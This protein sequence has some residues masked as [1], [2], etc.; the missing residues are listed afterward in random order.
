MVVSVEQAVSAPYATRQLADL[1]ARVIKVE[2]TGEGDFA[3]GYDS[4]ACGSSSY[5]VWLNRSKE[6]ITLDLKR[7]EGREVLAKLLARADVFVQNL[8]PGA[9]DRLSL[10]AATLR[11]RYAQMIV[12]DIDGYGDG[13]PYSGRPAYDLLMQCE[14]GLLSVTGTEE[15]PAK[16]G[17]SIADIA[18]GT[19]A[20]VGI[21]LA[22]HRRLLT[23]QGAHVRVSML[24]AI[25][26]WMSQPAYFARY[27]GTRPRRTGS[28]HSTIAPYGPFSCD[29]GATIFV[30]VQNDREWAR[31]CR[32]VL[33]R[34]DLVTDRRFVGNEPRVRHREQLEAVLAGW[35][36][37]RDMAAAV[38]RLERAQIACARMRDVGELW[39]H[40]QM[41]ARQRLRDIDTPNGQVAAFLPPANVDG[42]DYRMG[43]VPALGAH[44]DSL[45]AELGYD[46]RAITRL[47]SDSVI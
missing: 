21:L 44:T 2:R 15:A 23:G 45:L 38:E 30:A 18:A 40:P 7:A 1:G 46:A 25:G 10:G 5:F 35:F 20:Y 32:D 13:G 8:I 12:C 11:E 39:G 14:A 19:Q 27:G 29:D 33:G 28:R 16:V 26:E 17:I 36:R 34:P 37:R 47:K 6:S 42:I 3:R 43:P 31:L 22:L 4:T 9:A 24:E 41:V